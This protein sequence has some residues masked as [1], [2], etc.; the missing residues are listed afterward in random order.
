MA[1]LANQEVVFL[2]HHKVIFGE[3]SVQFRI[4]WLDEKS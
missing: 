4:D 3:G 1:Y 2:I